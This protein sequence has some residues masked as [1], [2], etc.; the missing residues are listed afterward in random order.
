MLNMLIDYR[1]TGAIQAYIDFG[2]NEKS[3]HRQISIGIQTVILR[4]SKYV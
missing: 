4:V 1:N 2:L 3:I